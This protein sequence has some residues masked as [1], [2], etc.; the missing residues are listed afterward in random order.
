LSFAVDTM[1]WPRGVPRP[2][3]TASVVQHVLGTPLGSKPGAAYA[4]SNFGY[5]V[6]GRIIE[7]VSGMSYQAYVRSAILE[8][9]G[10]GEMRLGRSQLT[11]RA[12]NEV[13]YYGAAGDSFAAHTR[14]PI[15]GGGGGVP[16]PYAFDLELM[17]AAAGWIGSAIDVARFILAVDGRPSRP[18]VLESG[19]VRA[20]TTTT[21][22]LSLPT[23][24]DEFLKR[25]QMTEGAYTVA[26]TDTNRALV[27]IRRAASMIS[28]SSARMNYAAGWYVD[29][30]GEHANWWHDG[31]LSGASALVA[32][33]ARGP[34][35]VALFNATP[36]DPAFYRELEA[37][38]WGLDNVTAWPAGDLFSR[39]R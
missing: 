12:P 10:A 19:S 37:L 22:P 26:T 36:R 7:R 2:A 35:W 14:P 24:L 21:R 31:R 33:T 9:A 8:P 1:P 39:Y 3:T 20:M 28:I 4:Y 23:T 25:L 32:R 6:L 29:A 16:R 11:L 17:D 38:M 34:V 13:K 5:S 15:R 27:V 18:D 30:S